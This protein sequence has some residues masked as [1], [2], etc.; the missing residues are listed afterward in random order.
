MSARGIFR[1]AQASAHQKWPFMPL[2][3]KA[4]FAF[5]PDFD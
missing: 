3:S 2:S 5:Q 4:P 1:R